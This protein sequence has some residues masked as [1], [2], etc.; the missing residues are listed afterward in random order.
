M[1]SDIEKG[2]DIRM[3]SYMMLNSL[4]VRAVLSSSLNV[5]GII[6]AAV[7]VGATGVIIGLLLGMASKIFQVPVDEKEIKVR[8]LLPGNNCGGCGYAG[9][10]ALAKAIATGEAPVN[11]CPVG[12]PQ[13]AGEIGKVM[14]QDVGETEKMVAYVKCSGT[15]DHTTKKYEYYG[16]KDCKKLALIPG[17]GDKSCNYGCMGYGSCVNVCEFDALHIVDGIAKVDKEA[18]VSCGKCIKE[19][20]NHLIELIPYSAEQ[21]VACNSNDKGKDVKAACSVGCIG[22]M[23]CT[24]QCEFDAITVTNN[25]A[26]IDY[27]KCTHCGKCAEKCPVKII[28]VE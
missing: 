28:R 4:P 11:G 21:R 14:G 3:I 17:H 22:C 12:G 16:I 1:S 24:K 2:V 9:C 15:C 19:C 13:V 7:I 10:D 6:L 18:C 26:K 27:S 8:E 20:P 25:L 5:K 23:L